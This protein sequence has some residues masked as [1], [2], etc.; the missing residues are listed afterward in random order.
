MQI[1]CQY[2]LSN[3]PNVAGKPLAKTQKNL[4]KEAQMLTA[5]LLQ[6]GVVKHYEMLSL[7]M[8][9][10]GLHA[11]FAMGGVSKERRDGVVYMYPNTRQLSTITDQ[12]GKATFSTFLDRF[13]RI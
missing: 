13:Y 7:D 3:H 9:G 1:L 5:R 6:E 12:L 11:L 10:N 8:M 4:V 2:L